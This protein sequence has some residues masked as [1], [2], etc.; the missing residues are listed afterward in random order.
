MKVQ[1]AVIFTALLLSM[2]VIASASNSYSWVRPTATASTSGTSGRNFTFYY[3]Y[4][5]ATERGAV[6]TTTVA[7]CSPANGTAGTFSQQNV[8]YGTIYIHACTNL[9]NNIARFQLQQPFRI[10]RNITFITRYNITQLG[11]LCSSIGLS[12]AGTSLNKIGLF[13][14]YCDTKGQPRRYHI[15]IGNS[16][17]NSINIST[18]VGAR[19]GM[20]D[21]M[22]KTISEKQPG[23]LNVTR[24]Y[25]YVNDTLLGNYTFPKN[26]GERNIRWGIHWEVVPYRIHN[27]NVSSYLDYNYVSM[28]GGA[29]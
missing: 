19:T 13:I 15:V 3:E 7:S 29:P 25:F 21:F 12:T 27:A 23:N 17:T 5:I 14:R 24:A 22:I 16:T 26:W 28:Q 20:N 10:D 6:Y 18:T 9:G 11:F 2:V 4:V 1:Q 8:I